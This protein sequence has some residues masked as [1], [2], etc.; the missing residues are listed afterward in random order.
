MTL[1]RPRHF[2]TALLALCC[3]AAQA[4]DKASTAAPNVTVLAEKL[5]MPGLN[6]E[7]GLRIYLPPSYAKSPTRRYPV[8]Y[9]HDGQ[10]LF[11]A[12]TG[13]AGEWGVDE[14]LNELA[15]KEGLELIVVGID[16]GG[17][18]R[19]SEMSLFASGPVPKPEGEAYLRFI[20]EVVK[21]LV[22][23]R[24]RTLPDR[25]HTGM[26]GSSMGG[27]ITHAALLR[28]PQVFGRAGVFSPSYW[29][30]M[31]MYD[32]AGLHA[33]P[34]GTRLY[35]YVGGNEGSMDADALRMSRYLMERNPAL[36]MEFRIAPAAGHNEAAWAA[37][38][39]RAVRWLFAPA[40]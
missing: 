25:A 4:T 37:E 32:E 6:R 5:A 34:D 21:P 24:Y 7:R 28:Y 14:A 15:A 11:D 29:A 17:D 33:L 40:P 31:R 39:P 13:F 9:M 36:A 35:L 2:A 23:Q 12:A 38:F 20:A 22:D 26:M 3:C 16:N 10:N 30:N 27:L 8:L 19:T 18:H 1:F